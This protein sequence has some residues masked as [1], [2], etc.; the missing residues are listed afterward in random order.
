MINLT[1]VKETCQFDMSECIFHESIGAEKE[2]KNH[3]K[4][5]LCITR[6]YRFHIGFYIRICC[7]Q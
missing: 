4:L 7:T 6:W 2:E 5:P 1:D 3:K